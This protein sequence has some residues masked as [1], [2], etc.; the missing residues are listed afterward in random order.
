MMTFK[1]GI[2]LLGSCVAAIASVGCIFELSYGEP[3]LGTLATGSILAASI[4]LGC[5]LFYAA[6]RSAKTN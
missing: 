2:F 4:P 3:E 5:L 1:S 6:V